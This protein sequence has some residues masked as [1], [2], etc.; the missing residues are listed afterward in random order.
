MRVVNSGSLTTS[1]PRQSKPC[2]T[3]QIL[4]LEP[5]IGRQG[6]FTIDLSLGSSINN[7]V[8]TFLTNPK[9][10]LPDV[11]LRING[12]LPRIDITDQFWLTYMG[13]TSKSGRLKTLTF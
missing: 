10:R 3:L 11:Y 2:I 4:K 12:N 13:R 1:R 9:S 5:T 6:T 7:I 8:K